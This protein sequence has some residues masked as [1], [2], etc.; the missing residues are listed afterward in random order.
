MVVCQIGS[1]YVVGPD[2]A[3]R[4]N[5]ELFSPMLNFVENV[6]GLLWCIMSLEVNAENDW[7]GLQVAMHHNCHLF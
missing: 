4:S 2:K 6:A 1:L 7:G 5:S 3:V